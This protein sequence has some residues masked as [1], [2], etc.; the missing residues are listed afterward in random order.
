MEHLKQ[1]TS[2]LD[3]TFEQVEKALVQFTQTKTVKVRIDH[4]AGCLRFG[5]TELESESMRSQLTVLSKQLQQVSLL[6]QPPD[7][8]KRQHER[9][10]TLEKIRVSLPAEHSA[11]LERKIFIE[12]RKEE[13]ERLAQERARE[14]MRIKA[15]EEAARKLE[16]EKR[17]AREQRLREQ[18]KQRM[19]QQKLEIQEKK[20]F[21]AA[22]GKKTDDMTEEQL[23][24]IDTDTLQKESQEKLAKEKE[25]ADRKVK[26]AAKKLDYLVR[27]IRI[28]ELP[29]VKKKY[30][31]R[32]RKDRERYEQETIEKAKQAKLQWESD[33]KDKSLL[34]EHG[35][36]AH[37]AEFE[38]MVMS[39]R[40]I[41]HEALCKEADQKADVEADEAKIRRARKRKEDEA[42]R[43]AEEEQRKKEEEQ[44]KK[45]EEEA[46]KK[47]EARREREAKEE[48]ARQAERKRMEEQRRREQE[49]GRAKPATGGPGGK[50]VPPSRRGQAGGGGDDRTSRF[51]GGGGAY[52]GGGR[53]EGRSGGSLDDGPAGGTGSRWAN[54]R[55][56]DDDRR[57]GDRFGGGDDR[58]GGD[59][60]RYGDRDRP[61]SGRRDDRG[62]SRDSNQ[63]WR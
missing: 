5:D 13:T 35:V 8:A 32:V 61:G 9:H 18:E 38:E 46:R 41:K 62:P 54:V 30:E 63:R 57:G 40:K 48:E 55:G 25:E 26:E 2:G 24:K 29:L 43:I 39:G 23:V 31:E 6:L 22:M 51:G 50:Y 42:R 28:E 14:E 19:I 44:R 58:R 16:E 3:M 45:A 21:L 11:I 47:E 20:R 27:A 10:Q 34:E 4:R 17:I 12:K 60:G 53:Y 49:S 7:V 56:P 36:F 15:E 52:P 37:F 1:L 59:S 33:V